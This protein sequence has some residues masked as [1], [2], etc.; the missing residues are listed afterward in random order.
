MLRLCLETTVSGSLI[1][2][3]KNEIFFALGL[4]FKPFVRH[5]KASEAYIFL[6]TIFRLR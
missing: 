1:T 3:G 5:Q 2:A 6:L 4:P